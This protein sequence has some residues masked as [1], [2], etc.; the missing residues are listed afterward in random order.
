MEPKIA[1]K[2]IGGALIIG[3]CALSGAVTAASY[4]ERVAAIRDFRR[5]L[6]IMADEIRF[7]KGVLAEALKRQGRK[8][9]AADF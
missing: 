6:K 8:G 1:I 7:R 2:I 3:S 5:R 9:L 4:R